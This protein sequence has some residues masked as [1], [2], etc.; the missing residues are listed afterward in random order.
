MNALKKLLVTLVAVTVLLAQLLNPIRASADGETT[1][2]PVE[3]SDVTKPPAPT[4]VPT[5]MIPTETPPAS[6][7]P[8]VEPVS[9]DVPTITPLTEETATEIPVVESPT[10]TPTES[11]EKPTLLEVIE[12]I[13]S[14]TNVVVLDENGQPLSLTTQDA[15]EVVANGDPIWC[16]NGVSP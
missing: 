4:D 3:T 9:T 14:E 16:P 13:P 1:P 6:D 11:I 12:E 2:P 7:V 5:E 10:I 8:K 15:S